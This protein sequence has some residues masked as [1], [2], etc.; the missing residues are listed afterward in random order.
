MDSQFVEDMSCKIIPLLIIL[1]YSC[2]AASKL[3]DNRDS[4]IK[5]G[6]E[7]KIDHKDSEILF[8]I[9]NFNNYSIYIFQPEQLEIQR[10]EGK[11]WK[12]V[13]TLYCPCGASC[14]PPREYLQLKPGEFMDYTWN[15]KE[16]WC[17]NKENSTIPE[18]FEK[19]VS[20]GKY[21]LFLEYGQYV[22]EPTKLYYEFKIN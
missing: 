19:N 4:S 11:E 17:V 7:V 20:K 16:S 2:N 21:R 15:K 8:K 3:P 5:N 10:Q 1:V 18:T 13:R 22:K 14:P 12:R 9:K 6:I